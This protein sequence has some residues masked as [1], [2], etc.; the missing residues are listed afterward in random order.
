MKVPRAVPPDPPAY[1]VREA[2]DDGHRLPVAPRVDPNLQGR[3]LAGQLFADTNLLGE[4]TD[5]ANDG[6]RHAASAGLASREDRRAL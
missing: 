5:L 3:L 4:A 1:V 6:R 2:L